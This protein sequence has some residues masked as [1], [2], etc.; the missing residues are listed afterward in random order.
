[1]QEDVK[2]IFELTK[3]L[4]LSEALEVR[5]LVEQHIAVLALK[6]LGPEA[7]DAIDTD[8]K[9]SSADSL[10]AKQDML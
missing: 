4:S 3:N 5:Q 7:L 6:S 1:M 2:K 8:A 10:V 9:L